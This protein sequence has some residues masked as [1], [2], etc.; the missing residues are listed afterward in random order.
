MEHVYEYN[1]HVLFAI[2]TAVSILCVVLF[3]GTLMELY[4]DDKDL[5]SFREDLKR[6][7]IVKVDG[8]GK[9]EV[10]TNKRNGEVILRMHE[11][12]HFWYKKVSVDDIY[13]WEDAVEWEVI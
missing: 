1:D 5:K 12:G 10:W 3:I 7:D 9:Q 8:L 13:P 11:I 6:G 4:K 2:L